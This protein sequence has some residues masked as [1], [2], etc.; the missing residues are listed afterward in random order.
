MNLAQ[1]VLLLLDILENLSKISL[2]YKAN[3]NKH[4]SIDVNKESMI[5]A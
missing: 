1:M 5:W 4:K 3:L 2:I